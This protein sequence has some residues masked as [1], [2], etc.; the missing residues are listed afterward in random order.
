MGAYAIMLA[1]VTKLV[2]KWGNL[3]AQLMNKAISALRY[4][5]VMSRRSE[6]T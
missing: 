4:N 1:V 2:E 5:S 6:R 3:P